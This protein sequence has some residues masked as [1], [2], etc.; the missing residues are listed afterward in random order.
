VNPYLVPGM[1]N[2]PNGTLCPFRHPDHEGFYVPVDHSETRYF[3]FTDT[4]GDSSSLLED[5]RLVIAYGREKCGKTALLNRC[6]KF[7]AD[8]L[9]NRDK[10]GVVISLSDESSANF[11]VEDRKKNVFRFVLDEIR[12]QDLVEA[13]DLRELQ[14]RQDD[15][16]FAYKYLSDCLPASAVVIVLLPS[17]EVVQELADYAALVRPRMLLLA[18]SSYVDEVDRAWRDI[19]GASPRVE[20]IRLMVD[21]LRVEDGWAFAEARQKLDE[22]GRKY[23][24]VTEETMRRVTDALKPSI[25]Q[26][27]RLLHGVYREILEQRASGDALISPELDEVNYE[28]I[29]D[30]F[31]RASG[32]GL[33]P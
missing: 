32:Q 7:V 2:R 33:M 17:V 24:K 28:H 3:E 8:D 21:R 29:T 23:P 18:E 5:G 26:L 10:R 13:S 4:I 12:K 27:Q 15:L 9:E 14:S 20:P 25:G 1:E 30:F 19:R 31:L 11:A 22:E 16:V 6:A